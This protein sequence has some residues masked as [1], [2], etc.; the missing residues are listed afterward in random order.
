M[1]AL[2]RDVSNEARDAAFEQTKSWRFV[3]RD[4]PICPDHNEAMRAYMTRG[5]ITYYACRCK[6]CGM[7]SKSITLI[8]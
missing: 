2:N 4:V 1:I 3:R 5:R 8:V 7:R 6:D